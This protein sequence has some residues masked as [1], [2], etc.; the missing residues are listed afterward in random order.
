MAIT[1]PNKKENIS[2]TDEILAHIYNLKSLNK[3]TAITTAL[4]YR[5][6]YTNYYEIILQILKKKYPIEANLRS[7]DKLIMR[8]N[9]EVQLKGGRFDGFEY[10]TVND[11]VILPPLP[12]VDGNTS[13]KLYGG[14]NNG[15]IRDIFIDNVYQRLPVKGKTVVDVGANIADSSIYFAIHGAYRVIGIEPFPKNY[16]LARKNIEYN[17]L[18]NKVRIRLA[19]CAANNNV[20]SVDP[21][22][23]RGIYS[24][25]KDFDGGIKV[26]LLTLDNILDTNRDV[27]GDTCLVLKMDCEG[28]EY[29]TVL[30]ADN[31]TLKRFSHIIIEYHLGYKNL[32][33]KLEK[34]NFRVSVTRPRI[35]K[36][37]GLKLRLGYIFGEKTDDSVSFQD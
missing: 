32:K 4:K 36:L 35:Y 33:E 13:V 20:I 9:R 8:N 10:D 28:C 16:E 24:V 22:Y 17:N 18:S 27:I 6:I 3:F 37:E 11:I 30:S 26:P 21:T 25:L 15:D 2:L 12:Y 34:N 1:I 23:E 7:G 14:V 31:S 29:E 5:R 19:G